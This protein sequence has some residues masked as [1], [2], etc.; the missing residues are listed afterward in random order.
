M[1]EIN[2]GSWKVALPIIQGGMGVGVSLSNLASAVANEG[3]IG[4]ISAAG[5]G[6]REK[7]FYSNFLEANIRALKKEIRLARSKTKGFLGVNIMV[8]MSNFSDMVKTAIEEKI[9]FIFSGAGLPLDLPKYHIEGSKTKL[10]PII[11]SAKAARIITKIWLDRYDYLPDA[12]VVEGP[13]AGGHL[14]FKYKDLLNKQIDIKDICLDVKKTLTPFENEKNAN[15][16]VFA[17]GGIYTGKDIYEVQKLGID[18]VQ[19]ATRFVTTEECDAALEFKNTYINA[20]EEDI[21]LIKSPVGMPGRAI[22]NEY[23]EQVNK[24]DKKPFACPYHCI[25]TCDYKDT[26]YCISLALINAQKGNLKHGFAFAGT[27]A[28]RADKIVKVSELVNNL[29][30]EYQKAKE[31]DI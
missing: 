28:H 10:V 12:F 16:P 7:D 25:K 26:P 15:I 21:V 6:F 19:M 14:G 22:K 3:G 29:K 4:V 20:K 9:D 17:A 2:I 23:I 18:G 30:L 1:K 31:S 5:V 13:K 11:S 8:A 24:G 27:N